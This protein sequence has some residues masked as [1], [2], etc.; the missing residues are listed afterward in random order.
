MKKKFFI[1]AILLL[2]LYS[3]N[4]Q[5]K[6]VSTIPAPYDNA[7][8]LEISFLKDN[9]MYGWACGKNGIVIRTTNGGETWDYTIIPFAY[10]L[11]SI[12]FINEKVGYTSG[13]VSGGEG[14][15]G[16][17][18]T[19]DGGANWTNIT[20]S[21]NVDLWG[22]Y[23]TDL[24]TVYC[25]GGGCGSEQQ[26]YRSTNGG[27][28]WIG[29]FQN[30]WESGL[31]DLFIDK[32]TGIGYASGSGTIWKT[33]DAGLTW[34]FFCKSGGNDWQEDIHLSGNTFLV[35]YSG[36]CTGSDGGGGARMSTDL[37]IT[38]NQYS[39]GAPMF[40]S[41]LNNPTT[42]WVVGWNRSCYYTSDAGKSWE[43]RNCGIEPGADLDDIWFINDTTGFVVGVGVYKYIGDKKSIPEILADESF[44]AC[45]G[46]TITLY[47]NSSYDY[48]K[49]S[50]GETTPSIKVTKTGTYTLWAAHNECDSATSKPFDVTFFP[51]PKFTLQVSDSTG[52]CE[53]DSVKASVVELF[54][55][56][57]WSTGETAQEII[58]RKSGKYFV[59]VSDS[60]GCTSKDSLSLNFSPLPNTKIDIIGKTNF[61]VG[62]SVILSS[63]FEYPKYEW[64]LDNSSNPFSDKRQVNIF[65]S[66]KYKLITF[67]QNN[68]F[69][70]DE[71]DITVRPDTNSY[72]LAVS[73]SEDFSLDSAK[74]PAIICK[75]IKIT[76]QSSAIQ[77]ISNILLFKNRSFSIPQ[78][79]LPIILAPNESFE[80]Q[81][82]YSPNKM[83]WERDTILINDKCSPHV[84][85]LI[86][87]GIPNNYNSD[88]KCD[89]PLE[90]N[91]IDIFGYKN[92]YDGVPFPNPAEGIVNLPFKIV[93]ESDKPEYE[94]YLT[95]LFRNIKILPEINEI[96]SSE[97]DLSKDSEVNQK[98][99]TVL[100]CNA[101]FSTDKLPSGIYFIIVN[102]DRTNVHKI[103]INK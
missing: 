32:N 36:G 85:P 63:R 77:T 71:V 25:I 15:G 21:G 67:N 1:I 28:N 27:K 65:Q 10:Q 95:D 16:I 41:F 74:F 9:P 55:S 70:S 44:P 66:G 98:K 45:Q 79:Q 13:L 94:I 8:Y 49:W 48:Y 82:C 91:T 7:Y 24:N 58:I 99:A 101:K 96:S 18:K 29:Y 84:V 69:S 43:N 100:N 39:F 14:M 93:F 61:C 51:K 17:F 4:A 3:G 35:P 40:G 26:F 60:N 80:F 76:N 88:S 5:W 19:T 23:T 50:T 11:E 33:T 42:G 102:S 81:V 12:Y 78:S 34:N 57:N 97:I 72:N 56:I 20:P 103:L 22:N 53:G 46:D 86:A 59:T 37:G 87:K 6:K 90:F 54:K 92:I 83:D 52:L 38:W 30:Y 64:Y 73:S 68:C 2:N 47:T 75:K 31:S 89:V 62:D